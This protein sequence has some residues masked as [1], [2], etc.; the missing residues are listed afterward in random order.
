MRPIFSSERPQPPIPKTTFTQIFDTSGKNKTT[1]YRIFETLIQN[2]DNRKK[3]TEMKDAIAESVE[4]PRSWQIDEPKV[5][6]DRL[7]NNFV[8]RSATLT[9]GF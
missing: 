5:A 8:I 6:I 4:P 7:I 1:N 9:A 3:T 2:S